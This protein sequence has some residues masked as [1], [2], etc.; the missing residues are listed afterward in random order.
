VG[1][2]VRD[3]AEQDGA[4]RAVA[5]RAADEEVQAGARLGQL[6]GRL[7]MQDLATAIA[8]GAARSSAPRDAA[9]RDAA[10]PSTQSRSGRGW[11]SETDIGADPRAR[12]G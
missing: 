12:P 6:L 3:A 10:E 7:P 4:G 5:A 2:G 9:A 11:G 1:E 8:D